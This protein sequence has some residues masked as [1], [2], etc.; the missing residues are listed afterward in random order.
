MAR[1]KQID[2]TRLSGKAPRKVLGGKRLLGKPVK[3]SKRTGRTSEPPKR[4][5]KRKPGSTLISTKISTFAN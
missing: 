4:K 3:R 5:Y 2:G 1:T